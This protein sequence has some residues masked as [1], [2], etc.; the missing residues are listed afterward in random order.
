MRIVQTVVIAAPRSTVWACI[1]DPSLI[2]RWVEG[3]VSHRYLDER[4]PSNPVGQR[5]EQLLG[6]DG[7]MRFVGT[8]NAFERPEHYAFSIPSSA[9]S[10]DVHFRLR[11]QG[12]GTL[13][14]YTIDVVL[15]TMVAKTVGTV[16]RPLIRLFVRKQLRRLKT[17]AEQTKVAP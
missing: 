17:L 16:F 8:L 10:S 15:H 9:Y 4:N 2:V 13:L 12:D 5:F 3:L 6:K 14:E 7:S 1:D 11:P